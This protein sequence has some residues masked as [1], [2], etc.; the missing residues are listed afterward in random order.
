MFSKIYLASD[1]HHPAALPIVPE[2]APEV[3]E[4]PGLVKEDPFISEL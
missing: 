3:V 4:L 1:A 2:R